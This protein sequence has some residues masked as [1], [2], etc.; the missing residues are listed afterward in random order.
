MISRS[1]LG[2]RHDSANAFSVIFAV[3][4]QS[5][6]WNGPVPLG[7][8]ANASMPSSRHAAGAGIIMED[9]RAGRIG[10]GRA[11]RMMTLP[12]SP[13]S[14]LLMPRTSL[15]TIAPLILASGVFSQVIAAMTASALNGSPLEKVTFLR[16]VNCQDVGE[17]DFQLVASAGAIAPFLSRRV[18]PSY[19]ADHR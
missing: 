2:L 12:S 11:V 17:S 15:T 4:P 13:A 9:K 16:K 10:S 6:T 1:T 8:F 5:F 14:A 19:M 3:P 7:A 18:R